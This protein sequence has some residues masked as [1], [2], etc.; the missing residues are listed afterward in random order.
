MAQ[1]LKIQE[2]ATQELHRLVSSRAL[3]QLLRQKPRRYRTQPLVVEQ[4]DYVY[5]RRPVDHKGQNPYRGPGQVI[6]RTPHVVYVEHSGHL[7]H[8]H[9][10]DVLPVQQATNE[11]SAIYMAK[12][13]E[14]RWA[15]LDLAGIMTAAAPVVASAA[16]GLAKVVRNG[17]AAVLRSQQVEVSVLRKGAQF[18][19]GDASDWV[20]C[21]GV[22]AGTDC[23]QE[24]IFE[25]TGGDT[26]H[27]KLRDRSLV[28]SPPRG[29]R[30]QLSVDCIRFDATT[31]ILRVAGWEMQIRQNDTSRV[32]P[33]L[34]RMA[35]HSCTAHN[36]RAWPN[37]AL[38]DL[39]YTF[40]GVNHSEKGYIVKCEESDFLIALEVRGVSVPK[41]FRSDES[42]V[43]ASA[44]VQQR[45][46][47]WPTP[48]ARTAPAPKALQIAMEAELAK[49]SA[50]MVRGTYVIP[51][52]VRGMWTR[53]LCTS[54]RTKRSAA[55]AL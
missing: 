29:Q 48:I 8:V 11:R 5:Y 12:F 25:D 21:V 31:N 40:Q 26:N 6:G 45:C 47:I 18:T 7:V 19:V 36:I 34:R 37:F 9:P 55:R 23:P 10:D 2:V 30:K 49:I 3:R 53:L 13:L 46:T 50:L 4:G 52:S 14:S 1:T 51:V 39:S 43:H 35:E 15:A 44:L 24:V 42:P 54:L 41:E 38:C 28:Y 27:I 20:L 22:K 33:R 32:L 17:C 16:L